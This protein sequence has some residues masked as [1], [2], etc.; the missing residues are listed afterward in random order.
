MECIPSIDLRRGGVVRL[1]QGDFAR[2]SEYSHEPVALAQ[3]YAAAGAKRLHVVDLDSAAGEG[4]NL[5]VI[6]RLCAGADLKVQ[7]GGG[8]RDEA[9]LHALLDAGAAAVVIG[10]LAVRDPDKVRGWLKLHGGERI[11][12]AFDVRPDAASSPEVLT[13][14]WRDAGGLS[15]WEL[16]PRYL[17]AGLKKVLCTDVT[18]DGLLDGPNITLYKE[19][20]R[21]FPALEWQ[22]S[23][24]VSGIGDVAALAGAG[25]PAIIIGRAL[26]EGRV[27]P[28]ILG[29]HP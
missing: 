10:S 13:N 14:A 15:L 12:L 23:G 16:V 5:E 29:V 24:G 4:T 22:A 3:S 26:L 8:V 18:R 28:E 1:K 20:L 7:V 21:R 9:G 17:D 2:V 19:C 6:R 11:V 27:E 25:L